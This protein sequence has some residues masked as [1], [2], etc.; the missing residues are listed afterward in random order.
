MELQTHDFVRGAVGTSIMSNDHQLLDI[1]KEKLKVRI[2][3][4]KN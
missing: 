4:G 1:L 3:R 2:I